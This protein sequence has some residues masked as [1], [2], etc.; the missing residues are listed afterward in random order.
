MSRDFE[1][2]AAGA[3]RAEPI[4]SLLARALEPP[5]SVTS[6]A[7]FLAV[8]GSFAL[9]ARPRTGAENAAPLG[10]ILC[11]AAA[12]IC[13]LAAMGVEAAHRNHGI[14]RALLAAAC[15]EAAK[16]NARQIFLEVSE[17]NGPAQAFY[18]SQGFSPV[19]RRPGYY[20]GGTVACDALVLRLDL[21]GPP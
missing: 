18:L 14:G 12:G 2:I 3:D 10:F 9:L 21:P 11:R 6:V 4:A 19:A 20:R 7:G 1:I 15:A 8:P 13:D 17:A 16:L 5:W